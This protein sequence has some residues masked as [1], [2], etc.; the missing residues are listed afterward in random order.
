MDPRYYTQPGPSSHYP[1]QPD[2]DPANQ[3]QVTPLDNQAVHQYIEDLYR[4]PTRMKSGPTNDPAFYSK[5]R[6][7]LLGIKHRLEQMLLVNQQ[8]AELAQM[9]TQM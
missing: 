9:S 5:A 8:Q 7:D 2:N 3:M 4:N 6:H 1:Q